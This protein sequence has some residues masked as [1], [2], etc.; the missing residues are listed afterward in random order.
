MGIFGTAP[1]W[2]GKGGG[3]A[4]IPAYPTIMKFATVITYLRKIQKY[5]N[6][7][8]HPLISADISIF[9]LE[10]STFCYI[11]KYRYR[12]YFGTQLLFLLKFCKSLRIGLINIVTILMMS[13]KMAALGLLR[14]KV[15]WNKGS[16]I[17]IS[18]HDLTNKILSR[19]S[20]YITDVIIWPKFG[21][22]SISIREVIK[23]SIL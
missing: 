17:I 2:G 20:Y 19:D 6:H 8:S 10:M 9:S 7:V 15:F 13:A 23:T 14:I 5:I 22:S 11:K 21:N 1:G 18:V 4:K 12:L 16:S 3:G